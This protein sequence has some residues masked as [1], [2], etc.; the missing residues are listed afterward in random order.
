MLALPPFTEKKVAFGRCRKLGKTSKWWRAFPR[1]KSEAMSHRYLLAP[2]DFVDVGSAWPVYRGEQPFSAIHAWQETYQTEGIAI[3]VLCLW[4]TLCGL[5]LGV[6]H[7]SL[8][9]AE[10]DTYA[11]GP[12]NTWDCG[13]LGWIDSARL[14]GE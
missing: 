2:G 5:L 3:I 7:H 1:T 14:C 12:I 6:F 4:A 9:H 8:C 13:H 10:I 11:S